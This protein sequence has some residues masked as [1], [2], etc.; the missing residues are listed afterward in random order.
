VTQ[1]SGLDRWGI[2]EYELC[3]N[4][5]DWKDLVGPKVAQELDLCIESLRLVVQAEDDNDQRSGQL[6]SISQL[7]KWQKWKHHCGGEIELLKWVNG[8]LKSFVMLKN[9]NTLA[10]T[11]GWKKKFHILVDLP[12][13]PLWLL[14]SLQFLSILLVSLSS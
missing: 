12:L 4:C 7:A 11:L 5:V 14:P 9:D 13:D 10:A 2:R 6:A 1:I 3:K 8:R